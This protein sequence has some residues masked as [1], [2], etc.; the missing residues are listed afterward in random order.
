MIFTPDL[1][2]AENWPLSDTKMIWIIYPV[3]S[4]FLRCIGLIKSA[5]KITEEKPTSTSDCFHYY[6]VKLVQ[7]N[8]IAADS[9]PINITCR[10]KTNTT[11]PF[12][13]Q[14]ICGIY[15]NGC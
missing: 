14:Y 2:T 9:S 8:K 1:A 3:V 4:F 15:F 5:I 10:T 11:L 13:I 7:A 6:K 12:L